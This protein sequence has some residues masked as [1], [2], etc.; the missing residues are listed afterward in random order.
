MGTYYY[1]DHSVTCLDQHWNKSDE[2]V[3][4][5][6][7]L[8]KPGSPYT[9]RIRDYLDTELNSYKFKD[10]VEI[11]ELSSNAYDSW[12]DYPDKEV[13]FYAQDRLPAGPVHSTVY[14]LKGPRL[15]ILNS[16][17][18]D[19]LGYLEYKLTEEEMHM[20]DALTTPARAVPNNEK[21]E[22]TIE[23]GPN[24]Y[25]S[26]QE[27]NILIGEALLN[28]RLPAD[29]IHHLAAI[30]LSRFIPFDGKNKEEDKQF[31]E[32]M[33]RENMEAMD[34]PRALIQPSAAIVC[35]ALLDRVYPP[36]HDR[37]R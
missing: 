17:A 20:Q 24:N 2:L 31:L 29:K 37:P 11:T 12:Q 4:D 7:V 23:R 32:R 30:T 27:L 5:L 19:V 9:L 10:R 1:L 21:I 26:K 6:H 13:F 25:I 3:L 33:L 22:F 18:C 16:L 35:K 34:I 8:D 36:E 28:T 14:S 15:D